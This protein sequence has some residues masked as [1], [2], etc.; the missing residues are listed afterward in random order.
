MRFLYGIHDPLHRMLIT[1]VASY[2]CALF[3]TEK[4][5]TGTTRLALPSGGKEN[6][7]ETNPRYKLKWR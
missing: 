7:F 5:M 6:I 1:L 2:L 4:R 3:P